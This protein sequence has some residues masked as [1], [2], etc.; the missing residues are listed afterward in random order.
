MPDPKPLAFTTLL[1]ATLAWSLSPIFIRQ[2][3]VVFDPITLTFIRYAVALVPLTLVSWI[4]FRA[5][6]VRLLRSIPLTAPLATLTVVQQYTW[7][8]GTY[9]ATATTAQLITKLT[10]PFTIVFAFFLFHEERAAVRHPLFLF[11]VVLSLIGMAAVITKDAAAIRPTVDTA[12]ALLITTAILWAV[13]NVWSKHMVMNVHPVPLFGVIALY[14]TAAFGVGALAFGSPSDWA[15]FTPG[16]VV[17]WILSG[18]FP[19]AMAHPSYNFAQRHLG[20]SYC[21]TFVLITPLITWLLSFLM[22]PGERLLP[23]QI[24]GGILLMLGTFAVTLAHLRATAHAAPPS[25]PVVGEPTLPEQR[26]APTAQR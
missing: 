4:R 13:Y 17:V 2:L 20:S 3:S 16:L 15:L 10:V 1:L 14:V 11:G 19:L 21:T 5:D 6:Y 12:T 8:A 26:V 25:V 9:G 24:G 7:V 18:I 22:L 23:T